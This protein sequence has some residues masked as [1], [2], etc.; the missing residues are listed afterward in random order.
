[1]KTIEQYLPDQPFF[2][3]LDPS[4]IAMLAGCAVNTHFDQGDQVFRQGDPADRFYVV[5]SGRVAIEVHGPGSG[6]NGIV[7]D[8]ADDGDVVGWAWFVPP[9][10][11]AFDARATAPTSTIAFDAV[12]LR[13]K[14]AAEPAVGYA[15][16][17]RVSQSMYER[18]QG[19]RIRLLDLYGNPREQHQ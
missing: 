19:A 10:R 7:I 4:I 17:Q 18:M 11:W 3:G 14:C 5:R 12:C 1:M 6:A 16:M 13:H 9:Y 8:T 2:A 15:L